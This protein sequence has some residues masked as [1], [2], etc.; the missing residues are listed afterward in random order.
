MK[1]QMKFF[2]HLIIT[3]LLISVVLY[4]LTLLHLSTCLVQSLYMY[5]YLYI[6]ISFSKIS[7][8]VYLCNEDLR[9]WKSSGMVSAID[10]W[11]FLWDNKI[12]KQRMTE[13]LPCHPLISLIFLSHFVRSFFFVFNFSCLHIAWKL[14]IYN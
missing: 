1:N 9:H 14:F 5:M 11:Y 6:G 10:Y 4:Q 8:T 13:K 3:Y 12:T 7:C 2:R